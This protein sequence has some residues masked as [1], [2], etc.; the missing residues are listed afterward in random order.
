MVIFSG[1]AKAG[2]LPG[3]DPAESSKLVI[4]R[5][6]SVI[7]L[8]YQGEKNGKVT[9]RIFDENNTLVHTDKIYSENGFVRPYNFKKLT[10]GKYRFEITDFEGKAEKVVDYNLNKTV[11]NTAIRARL[12]PVEESESKMK[13][14]VLGVVNEPVFVRVLDKNQAEIFSE[15]INI[16]S[17]FSRVYN[18][19][20]LGDRYVSFEVST[21]NKL[22]L[23]K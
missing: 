23:K 22:L 1:H 5:N 4:N 21:E 14:E 8:F 15:T 6:E 10:A 20:K 7:K 17:S 16:Q 2:D 19:K 11:R 18:L 3:I 9:I 13:L 12:S